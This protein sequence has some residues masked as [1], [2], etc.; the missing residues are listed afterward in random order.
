MLIQVQSSIDSTYS[1][2]NIH[3]SALYNWGDTLLTHYQK[4]RASWNA[5]LPTSYLGYWTDNGAY[6]YYLTENK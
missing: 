6:Y 4:S 5:D 2:S 3:S 1:Q